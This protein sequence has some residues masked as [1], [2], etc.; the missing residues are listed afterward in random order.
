MRAR[1]A[2][3]AACSVAYQKTEIPE[4]GDWED[5]QGRET[6]RHNSQT[7]SSPLSARQESSVP[8]MR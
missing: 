1:G 7:A 3:S 4:T 6:V 2:H 5:S 8:S